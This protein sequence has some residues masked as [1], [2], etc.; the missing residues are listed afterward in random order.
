MDAGLRRRGCLR[1]F[2]GAAKNG[3]EHGKGELPGV[4][5]LERG[6]VAGEERETAGERVLGSMGEFEPGAAGDFFWRAAGVG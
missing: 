2:A 6:V 5:V 3:E 4:G 1:E